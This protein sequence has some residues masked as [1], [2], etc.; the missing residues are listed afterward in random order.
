M[1]VIGSVNELAYALSQCAGALFGITRG[2]VGFSEFKVRFAFNVK[3]ELLESAPRLV[4]VI[5]SFHGAQRTKK[6]M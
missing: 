3:Q 5:E 2:L 1:S 6:S 4:C